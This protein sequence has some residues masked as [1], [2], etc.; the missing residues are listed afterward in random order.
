MTTIAN[1]LLAATAGAVALCVAAL[2][3]S[4]APWT[5]PGASMGVP[6]GF[7]PPP[8]LYFVGAANYGIAATDVAA[9]VAVQALIWSPG[10]T[11]LGAQYAADVGLIEVEVGIHHV[12]YLRG[13]FN[14]FVRPVTLSWN[15]GNGFAVS[16]GEGIY[17]PFDKTDISNPGAAF[18]QHFSVSY[19]A[20][21]WIASI[22]AAYT[23]TTGG[24]SI[25]STKTPDTLD[26]DYTLAHTFGKW[27]LGVVGYSAWDTQGGFVG[28]GFNNSAVGKGVDVGVGALLGYNFGPVDL[29]LKATHE[30][31]SH[32]NSQYG[33][34]DTIV[35]VT[36]VI[37]IWNP[38]PPA[39]KPLVAKY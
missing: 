25:A 39:S 6:A 15:L 35:W 13:V 21:D 23:L 7:V 24:S 16:V 3:A 8:G 33:K 19:I 10:W 26:I 31:V 18:E 9:G 30:I 37:P 20:N 34:D 29:T 1:R 28:S 4:A 2:P 17:T 12:T 32:G 38:T 36:L 22:N 14:P 11:F 27:E 5:Q